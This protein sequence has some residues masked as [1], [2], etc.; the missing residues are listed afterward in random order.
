[1][2]F[3][4]PPLFPWIKCR[5]RKPCMPRE[6]LPVGPSETPEYQPRKTLG[7]LESFRPAC[8]AISTPRPQLSLT[9]PEIAL[10]TR[11]P[12]L[13][14]IVRIR[15]R[16]RI[17]RVPRSPDPADRNRVSSHRHRR[18]RLT[19]CPQRHHQRSWLLPFPSSPDPIPQTYS[20]FPVIKHF[21][22]R[23]FL[24]FSRNRVASPDGRSQR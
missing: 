16:Q 22:T 7:F 21:V 4:A 11:K 9:T 18:R 20:R 6:K 24:I 13:V 12:E 23:G 14:P 5:S 2:R 19:V 3:T 1:M 8:L 15:H 17:P 10:L